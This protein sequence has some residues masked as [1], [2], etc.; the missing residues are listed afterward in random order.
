M[1]LRG[2]THRTVYDTPGISLI[3]HWI[4]LLWLRVFGW[5]AEGQLPDV[6]KYVLIGAPHTSNWDLPFVLALAFVFRVKMYW[7]AKD[8][9]FRWP[10]GPFFRWL[11]GI[12][13]DRSKANGMVAQAVEAFDASERLVICVPP[14]GTRSK[15]RK[16]KTGFYYIAL[17]AKVPINLSFMDYGRRAGGLGTLFW[18]TGDIEADMKQ[19]QAFYAPI[20]GK[21]PDLF[22]NVPAG[23]GETPPHD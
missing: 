7:L 17:G 14:E 3:M 15:V 4:G 2:M 21:R 10:F 20:R 11:G 8:S 18:P 1:A 5:R 12:P 16:W 23:D 19:I 22:S 9:I 6:P 13:V